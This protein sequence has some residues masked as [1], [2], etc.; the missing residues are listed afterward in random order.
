MATGDMIDSKMWT[1]GPVPIFQG[2]GVATIDNP[3]KWYAYSSDYGVPPCWH[4]GLDCGVPKGTAIYALTSGTV[5]Q[6]GMAPYFR[7]NPV[8]VTSDNGYIEIYGHLWS[9]SVSMGQKVKPGDQLGFSGEQTVAGTMTPDGSGPHIHFEL[10]VPDASMPSG[11]KV[12]DPTSYIESGGGTAVPASGA[13]GTAVPAP[14]AGGGS[15]AP[16]GLVSTIGTYST[17]G[18]FVLAGVILGAI[19]LHALLSTG[20]VASSGKHLATRGQM[21]AKFL[22]ATV[23]EAK[24]AS[25]AYGKLGTP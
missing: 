5:T 24:L 14:G 3:C 18:I 7:P 16:L 2:F 4:V 22:K 17:R 6:T 21:A 15:T 19:G 13:G 20:N 12:I 10:R 23:P 1:I 9:D 8:F 25:V 11:F